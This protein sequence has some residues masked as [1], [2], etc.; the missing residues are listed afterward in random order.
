MPL[1]K[2]PHYQGV[3][4]NGTPVAKDG[5]VEVLERDVEA[6]ESEGWVVVGDET[7]NGGR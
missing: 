1:M 4:Y 6:L 7:D 2:P 3:T 5:A